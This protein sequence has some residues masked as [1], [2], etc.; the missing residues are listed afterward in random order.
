V[1][2]LAR[3]E[4]FIQVAGMADF[5]PG[6]SSKWL[7]RCAEARSATTTWIKGSME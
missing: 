5:D 7:M 3:L 4:E 6:A 2:V 1:K